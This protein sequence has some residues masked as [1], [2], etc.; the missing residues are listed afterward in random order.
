[1]KESINKELNRTD[2]FLGADFFPVLPATYMLNQAYFKLEE[3]AYLPVK[4]P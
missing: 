4:S 3:K 2:I 1:M